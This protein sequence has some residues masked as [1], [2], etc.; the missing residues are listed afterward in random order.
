MNT[1]NTNICVS[2]GATLA[3]ALPLGVASTLRRVGRDAMHCVSTMLHRAESPAI[4]STGQRPVLLI[5]GLSALNP[6]EKHCLQRCYK[7]LLIHA[8]VH[9]YKLE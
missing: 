2:V 7:Q 5:A 8:I 3:V 1:G 4:N 9:T 6:T